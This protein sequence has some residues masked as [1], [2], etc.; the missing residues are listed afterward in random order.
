MTPR[1]ESLVVGS[2]AAHARALGG[3]RLFARAHATTVR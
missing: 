2:W 1:A 3:D